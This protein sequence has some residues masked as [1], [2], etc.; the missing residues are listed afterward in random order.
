[1]DLSDVVEKIRHSGKKYIFPILVLLIGVILMSLPSK[2]RKNDKPVEIEAIK[3]DETDLQEEL[4]D[5]LCYIQGAGKVRVLL[6]EAVG[7]QT[8]YQTDDDTQINGESESMR[9]D[10]VLLVDSD[11]E[12]RGLIRQINPPSYQGAVILCRGADSASVRLSIMQAVISATGL[13]S[14]KITVLKMK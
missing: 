3:T 13:T 8:V 1:M 5:I 7:E 9:R 6:T 2:E 14:D 4:E 11:R 12:E 10:T